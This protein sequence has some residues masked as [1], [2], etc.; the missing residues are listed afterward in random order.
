MAADLY[1]SIHKAIRYALTGFLVAVGATGAPRVD[2]F[3]AFGG[4]FLCGGRGLRGRFLGGFFSGHCDEDEV[5][6]TVG[7][8]R[9]R[10][11]QGNRVR[12]RGVNGAGAVVRRG[13]LMVHG[14]CGTA[15]LA[16][17]RNHPLMSCITRRCNSVAAL[18]FVART[19]AST[20]RPASRVLG[21]H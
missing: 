8:V 16:A 2:V 17:P 15:F 4:G 20:K 6:K 9:A 5:E 12:E 1:A 21:C 7:G 11:T 3:R 18:A 19:V 13:R 10:T 14:A